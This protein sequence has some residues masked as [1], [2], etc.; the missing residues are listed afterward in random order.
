MPK[1]PRQKSLFGPEQ[2][3]EARVESRESEGSLPALGSPLST[4][5]SPLAT[6][7]EPPPESLQGQ[8]VYVID[9]HSLIHQLFHAMPEMTSPQGEPVG[10]VFGFARDI[11]SLLESKRPD[12]LFCAFDLPGKTFRHQLYEQYKGQRPEMD[13][14]LVPQIAA[15]RRMLDAM[16]IPALA[17]E[18][19]EA[20]DMLA[21]VA[22]LVDQRGGECY[23]VT[24]D[25]DCRQLITDRVKVY[26]IRKDAVFDREALKAAWGIA[27][28]A[29]GRF[30]G[31]G[32]RCDRQR[33]RRAA[34]RSQARPAAPGEIR[35]AGERLRARP[36]GLRREAAAEPDRRPPAGPLEPRAGQAGHQRAVR[37]PVDE[38]PDAARGSHAVA[39]HVPP[40]RISQPGRPG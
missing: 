35:D 2:G 32:G 10:A 8:T 30:P 33:P 3:R 37:D 1:R 24:G 26:N 28:G 34:G 14:D 7:D 15:I 20:D 19:F 38:R 22:R 13:P 23:L 18:S 9:A 21:T 11:F 5:D 31:P 17:C 36:R 25:K 39:G 40:L 16:G 12:Y 6:Q 29:G 4:L 27:P